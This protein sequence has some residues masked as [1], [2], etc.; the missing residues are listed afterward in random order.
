MDYLKENLPVYKALLDKG[1][2][3]EDFTALQKRLSKDKYGGLLYYNYFL[4]EKSKAFLSNA[5]MHIEEL[6]KKR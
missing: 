6:L 3:P 1:Y 4:T 2:K 5:C